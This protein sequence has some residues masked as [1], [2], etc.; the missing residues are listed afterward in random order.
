M[1]GIPPPLPR[2]FRPGQTSSIKRIYEP[3]SVTWVRTRVR[4][5]R[6]TKSVLQRDIYEDI[7][8]DGYRVAAISHERDVKIDGGKKA[9]PDRNLICYPTANKMDRFYGHLH[10]RSSTCSQVLSAR[11]ADGINLHA[12]SRQPLT[13]SKFRHRV[14]QRNFNRHRV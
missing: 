3:H 6:T 2:P 4:V 7:E 14:A 8:R 5:C 11:G 13:T 9:W 10:T 12:L 1:R